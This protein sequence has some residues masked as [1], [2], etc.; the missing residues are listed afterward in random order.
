MPK[1]L[2]T[3]RKEPL[4]TFSGS[5]SVHRDQRQF[6]KNSSIMQSSTYET[7]VVTYKNPTSAAYQA[8]PTS[9][10]R[11]MAVTIPAPALSPV[12]MTAEV[13]PIGSDVL[14]V[15]ALLTRVSIVV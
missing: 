8:P 12:V 4:P 15:P 5:D 7:L 10:S 3:G 6:V 11:I 9:P 14:P 1:D 13:G 2:T